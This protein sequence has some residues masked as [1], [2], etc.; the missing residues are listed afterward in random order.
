MHNE[1]IA[2]IGMSGK[3]GNY[4]TIDDFWEGLIKEERIVEDVSEERK[5]MISP[6]LK[7]LLG[8][9]SESVEFIKGAYLKEIDQFDHQLFKLSKKE[10]SLMDP[11]QR[12]FVEVAWS[13][14][15]DA[16]YGGAKLRGSNTGIYLGLSN[17]NGI[18]YIDLIE[19]YAQ[20]DKDIATAGNLKSITASRISYLLD[21]KGPSMLLDT[22]CSSSLSAV[23]VACEALR[24]GDCDYALAGGVKV[25][26][27]PGVKQETSD[28]EITS[29]DGFTKTF[30]QSA[31]GTGLGEGV[32]AILLKPVKKAVEDNDNIYAVIKGSAINQDGASLGITAPN[33]KAQ[34]EVI[35]KAWK[36]AE[37]TPE[38]ISYIEAHGTATKLGDPVEIKGITNSFRKYTDK[39]QFCGIGSLKSNIG[40]LD[41]AAGIA[42][43]IKTAL[44]VKKELIPATVNFVEPNSMINFI[45]SPVFVNNQMSRWNGNDTPRRSG[46]SSFGLSGTNVHVIIEDADRL[47]QDISETTDD[48]K[49]L[50][51]SAL[52]ERGVRK[53]LEDYQ[54]L[55]RG[56]TD[57]RM[58]DLC[59]TANTGRGM[60]SHRLAIIF[61]SVTELKELIEKLIHKDTWNHSGSSFYNTIKVVRSERDRTSKQ[62]LT[63]GQQ[64][65]LTKTVKNL[66]TTM[67]D[68]S[69][70]KKKELIMQLAEL[71]VNG[72]EVDWELYY[73][74]SVYRKISLPVYPFQKG[75]CWIDMDEC[76]EEKNRIHPLIDKSHVKSLKTDIYTSKLTTD[77]WEIGEHMLRDKFLLV[78][79]AYVEIAA[80]LAK[81]YCNTSEVRLMDLVC[82]S[83]LF[84]NQTEEKDIQIVINK[85]SEDFEFVILGTNK[86]MNQF[87]VYSRG[88]FKPVNK[89]R[90][91][92]EESINDVIER[93]D[94]IRVKPESYLYGNIRTSERWMNLQELHIGE[95]EVVGKIQLQQKYKSDKENYTLYPAL[96]DSALNAANS[97][98]GE[99]T[100]L[101]WYYKRINIYDSL[102]DS[103]TSY[104][105]LKK[106]IDEKEKV[107]TFDIL[108]IDEHGNTVVEVEDYAV[109]QIDVISKYFNTS[110]RNNLFELTWKKEELKSVS[111]PFDKER[112][113]L[114]RNDD[115]LTDSIMRELRSKGAEVIEIQVGDKFE[116]VDNHCYLIDQSEDSYND[117]L[118]EMVSFNPTHII[119]CLSIIDSDN[120]HLSQYDE[121]MDRAINSM[122]F[123]MKEIMKRKEYV[124]SQISVISNNVNEI[125]EE[126]FF[127]TFGSA[128]FGMA[129]SIYK[130]YKKMDLICVDTDEF[131]Q[132][133]QLI[134]EL[135]RKDKNVSV[136]FRQNLRYVQQLKPVN[137]NDVNTITTPNKEA[138]VLIT[139]GAGGI[140]LT[141]AKYLAS[142]GY[143]NIALTGR[144]KTIPPSVQQQIDEL[145]SEDVNMDYYPVDVTNKLKLQDLLIKLRETYGEIEGVIHS[146]GVAGSGLLITKDKADFEKVIDPKISGTLLLDELLKNDDLKF[147]ITC[148]SLTAEFSSVGQADYAAGNAFLDAFT[149]QLNQRGVKALTIDWCGWNESGMALKYGINEKDNLFKTINDAEAVEIF[150]SLFLKDL[151]R[152]LIIEPNNNISHDELL[153]SLNYRSKQPPIEKETALTTSNQRKD[154]VLTGK[155]EEDI[156]ETER[157]VAYIWY[158]TLGEAEI[159]VHDKFFEIG[160]DS[161]LSTY[162]LRK[163]NHKWPEVMDIT[164]IF[165]YSTIAEMAQFIEEKTN[166]VEMKDEF[167]DTL[168]KLASGKISIEEALLNLK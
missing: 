117:L 39:K 28:L 5:N 38:S 58:D 118:E 69:T 152:V 83:P 59:Y 10:A 15:E 71:Y 109:K 53:L 2:I 131:T 92:M 139:G 136:A 133:S 103:F 32:A 141:L 4:E 115:R 138:V 126:R 93:C 125:Y 3:L 140:G 33:S 55:L 88:S 6:Y 75:S 98:T 77:H 106:V 17:T 123:L 63:T 24:S 7:Y 73:S 22:A 124:N 20:D 142:K 54:L 162:L 112:I 101:P 127:N 44:A 110:K 49:I 48:M 42:G 62:D 128:L 9:R 72:A 87:E 27:I 14:L 159:N 66:I 158:K 119:H 105:K 57:I 76:K 111:I 84:L 81:I 34:E 80:S 18:D 41:A 70:E 108:L 95:K 102:P 153:L 25:N 30:D 64:K 45:Q 74:E 164:D 166:P 144:S 19:R 13:T 167:Q 99:G 151:K 86:E 37:I 29:G 47:N 56:S 160:G 60:Y 122:F 46:V 145:E 43:V 137:I 65:K 120:T 52:S 79:M 157:E 90:P 134:E 23:H 161:I 82:E 104:I 21:L 8:D 1:D 143:R 114:L 155:R 40:H 68:S 96:L 36:K 116:K 35:L 113:M 146:A 129:K 12:L 165:N 163:I 51:L 132:V 154:V 78:G 16:G 107:L 135:Y 85:H 91:Q 50:T 26:I 130:E 147:F 31:D 89:K 156:T 100:F 97:I 149:Y 11:I 168:S 61:K 121:H 150:D 67:N 148:S 94:H